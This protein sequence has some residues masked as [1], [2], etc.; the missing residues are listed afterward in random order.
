VHRAD[1]LRVGDEER[2]PRR[3]HAQGHNPHGNHS[4]SEGR[5]REQHCGER[6]CPRLGVDGQCHCEPRP[7]RVAGENQ[8]QRCHPQSQGQDVVE[9]RRSDRNVGPDRDEAR[10]CHEELAIQVES[11]DGWVHCLELPRYVTYEEHDH[12]T[13]D[14]AEDLSGHH[15]VVVG[16]P[17]QHPR[18]AER[19]RSDLQHR[20]FGVHV[21]SRMTPVVEV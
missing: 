8:R 5:K 2:E 13:E 19:H 14:G 15:T 21:Q 7:H 17:A 16:Q 12:P 3:R 20:V 6:Q 10:R 18:G 9:V 4:I 11:L 1:R